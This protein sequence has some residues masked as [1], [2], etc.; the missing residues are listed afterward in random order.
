[1]VGEGDMIATGLGLGSAAINI[2][3][4]GRRRLGSDA[5]DCITFA[6]GDAGAR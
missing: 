4:N 1:M 5:L 6:L 2:E 3:L